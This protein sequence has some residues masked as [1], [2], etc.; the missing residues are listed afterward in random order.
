[1]KQTLNN[2]QLIDDVVWLN[3]KGHEIRIEKSKSYHNNNLVITVH[4][5]TESDFTHRV[6]CNNLI[7]R[8]EKDE[9]S[10]YK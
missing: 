8:K 3:Y 7:D 2:L 4:T 6:I 10:N 9:T 1:M 5:D